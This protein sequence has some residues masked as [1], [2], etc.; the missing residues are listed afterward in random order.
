MKNFKMSIK[1]PA[2]KEEEKKLERD[3][4]SIEPY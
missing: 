2:K 4:D 1:K 3:A